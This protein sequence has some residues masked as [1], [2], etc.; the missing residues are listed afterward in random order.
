MLKKRG[1]VIKKGETAVLNGEITVPVNTLIKVMAGGKLIVED[2]EIT[3]KGGTW[4]GI[5]YLGGSYGS[6]RNVS[7]SGAAIGVDIINNDTGINLNNV[8]ITGSFNKGIHI[9]NS[10]S[11][12]SG[13]QVR[14]NSI[15]IQIEQSKVSIFNSIVENNEKG[16]IARGNNFYI[17]D[18]QVNSNKVYGLRMYGGGKIEKSSFKNNPAG[19]VLENGAGSIVLS[20]SFIESNSM[21]GIVINASQNVEIRGNLISN[22]GRHGIYIKENANPVIFENDIIYNKTYAVTGGGKII[23]CFIAYNNGSAYVDDTREKGRPDGIFSSSSSGVVKQILNVD[24]INELTFTS[25][26]R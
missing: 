3:S 1:F 19:I 14:D 15:G 17:K 6:I 16:I 26:L 20:D 10:R 23:N 25:S 21:D 11:N 8:E 22:N 12:L 4:A 18:S 24:Y 2:A 13:L 7:I 5:R 9:K